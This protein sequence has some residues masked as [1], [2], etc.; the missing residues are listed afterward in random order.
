MSWKRP[1]VI[2]RMSRLLQ[3]LPTDIRGYSLD[4]GTG[5]GVFTQILQ[6]LLG[7]AEFLQ[8][9]RHSFQ[10][11]VDLNYLGDLAA[12]PH[13]PQSLSLIVIAQVL[14]YLPPQRRRTTLSTLANLLIAGGWLVIIEYERDRSSSW[15]PYPYPEVKAR[16]DLGPLS[17]MTTEQIYHDKDPRRPKYAL[18]LR[19][20]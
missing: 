10:P 16:S 2:E 1:D 14:H 7:E 3:D 8:M 20:N 19:K 13:R 4:A 9:D 18:Y 11:V 12:L 15:L 5:S 6:H 17:N